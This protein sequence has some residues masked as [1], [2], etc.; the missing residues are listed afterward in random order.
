MENDSDPSADADW[1]SSHA[2]YSAS[3]AN[4]TKGEQEH[5]PTQAQGKADTEAPAGL[6]YGGVGVGGIGE[7]QAFAIERLVDTLEQVCCDVLDKEFIDVTGPSDMIDIQTFSVWAAVLE[8]DRQ[9]P[10]RLFRRLMRDVKNVLASLN[11][12]RTYTVTSGTHRFS[13]KAFEV[14]SLALTVYELKSRSIFRGRVI[15]CLAP[16]AAIGAYALVRRICNK[17]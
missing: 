12:D 2:V 10:R 7:Q 4:D 13:D 8:E 9:I 3:D 1:V 6:V 16:F 11:E 15:T 14:L 17:F 5:V